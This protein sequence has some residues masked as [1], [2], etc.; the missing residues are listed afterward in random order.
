[1]KLRVLGMNGLFPSAQGACSGYFVSAGKTR[2]LIDVGA[3]T[4]ARLLS[5]FDPSK[6]DALLVSHLH[7]DHFSDSGILSYYLAARGGKL[8]LD[9]LSPENHALFMNGSFKWRNTLE[10]Q[11]GEVHIKALP[12]RHPVPTFAY[13]LE[14][15]QK[16]LVYTGDTNTID[17]LAPFA[18]QADLLLCDAC[19]PFSKWTHDA[20]HLSARHAGELAKEANVKKLVLTHL[21]PF[22]AKE[23]LFS[24]AHNVFH[25]TVLAQSDG[26][27]TL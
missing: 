21:N 16:T 25:K 6:L 7:H 2:L 13:R 24:E 9:V 4:I 22:Y 15:N 1:M 5:F 23:D 14:C 26:V 19:M 11:I 18:N 20:P 3:G 12:V 8:P 10:I 17:A 27:Y